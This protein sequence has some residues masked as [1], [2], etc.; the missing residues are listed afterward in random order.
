MCNNEMQIRVVRVRMQ[1]MICITNQYMYE[2]QQTRMYP[3]VILL[4]SLDNCHT[5]GQL[6]EQ[7]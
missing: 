7:Q 2:S 3:N 4:C 6:N 1:E 5:D